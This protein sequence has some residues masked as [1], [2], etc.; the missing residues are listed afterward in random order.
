MKNSGN[1][2]VN[3][4]HHTSGRV[5]IGIFAL[6]EIVTSATSAFKENMNFDDDDDEEATTN[7]YHRP[8][9]TAE[10]SGAA[11][12]ARDDAH[13]VAHKNKSKN[14][15]HLPVQEN[16][17]KNEQSTGADQQDEWEEFEDSASKYAQLRRKLG[18]SNPERDDPDSNDEDYDDDVPRSNNHEAIP[19]E[20]NHNLDG[21]DDQSA[22]ANRRRE[23]LKEKPAWNLDQAQRTEASATDQP[24]AKVEEKPVPV[25]ETK[26]APSSGAYRPPQ[27]RAGAAVTVVTSVPQRRTKKEKPNIAS[28]DEF[29][30]LRAANNK[31]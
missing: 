27:L 12:A 31:K 6:L 15:S 22:Q 25:A 14:S 18:S 17:S 4:S 21:D 30:T 16:Q 7:N 1:N 29:P 19:G 11:A 23:Q 5:C 20:E 24:V 8:Q 3:R 9:A 13:A 26:P 28:T 10:P 2:W